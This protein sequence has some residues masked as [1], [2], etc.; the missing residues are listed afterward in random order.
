VASALVLLSLTLLAPHARAQEEAPI[1]ETGNRLGNIWFDIGSWIAQPAGLQ[2]T[3]ATETNFIPPFSTQQN[4]TMGHGTE[5]ETFYSLEYALPNKWGSFFLGLYKHRDTAFLSRS[6]FTSEAQTKFRDTRLDYSRPAFRT[7]RVLA[8]WSVGWRRIEHDRAIDVAYFALSPLLPVILP[9]A[10]Q[11]TCPDLSP[12]PDT[13]VE[14]SAYEGR[15][16]SAGIDLEFP[17]W[18][19][20]LVLEAGAG[21]SLLRGKL[22]YSYQSSNSYYFETDGTNFVQI[23]CD[24]PDVCASD[25]ATFDDVFVEGNTTVFQSSRIKQEDA[26]YALASERQAQD[27]QILEGY[28]GLRWRTPY[29]RLEVYLGFRQT[30]LDNVALR[31]RPTLQRASAVESNGQFQTTATTVIQETGSVVYE[32]FYGGLRFRLY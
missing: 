23:L 31:M 1:E 8:D 20:N 13:A 32:G 11:G 18:K 25:Y 28:L 6:T 21:A 4:L 24:N 10:C 14:S 29:Q 22:D 2:Y 17:L 12:E 15:G 19:R 7:R 16:L 27:A 5:T 9:P 3:P 26:A 30:R